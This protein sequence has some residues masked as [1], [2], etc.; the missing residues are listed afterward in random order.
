M[1]VAAPLA[2]LSLLL[3]APLAAADEGASD[4]R[5]WH[6]LV[7]ILARR[8]IWIADGTPVLFVDGV[9]FLLSAVTVFLIRWRPDASRMVEQADILLGRRVA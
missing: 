2:F 1:Q 6:R 9:T 5:T 7:G 4:G 8:L 3:A